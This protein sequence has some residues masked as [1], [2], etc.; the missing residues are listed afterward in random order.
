MKAHCI[1]NEELIGCDC[2]VLIPAALAAQINAKNANTVK[3]QI[4]LELANEP[5]TA[6]ADKILNEKG[7]RV[8]P[9]I[10]ANAGG[11]TVSYFEW[12]QG[13]SG[14]I[15]SEDQVQKRLR[16]IMSASFDSVWKFA[17]EKDVCMRTAAFML[18]IQRL[19]EA[20]KLRGRK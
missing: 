3:A 16:K 7:V 1:T 2:D 4:V 19:M 11:V 8:I 15:W 12:R 20:V 17:S 10:L 13:L 9:D 5:T 14:D 6:G 18:G